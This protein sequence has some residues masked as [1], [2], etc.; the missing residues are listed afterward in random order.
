[1]KLDRTSVGSQDAPSKN[2]T[3]GDQNMPPYNILLGYILSWYSD[4]MQTGVAL[5]ICPVVKEIYIYRGNI[6]Q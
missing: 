6:H 5:K 2:R 3:V 4:K 1:M